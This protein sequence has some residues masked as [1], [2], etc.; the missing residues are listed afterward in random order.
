MCSQTSTAVD[1][2]LFPNSYI[3]V[4]TLAPLSTLTGGSVIRY[5]YFR[6]STLGEKVDSQLN[7][8]FFVFHV[9]LYRIWVWGVKKACSFHSIS[10]IEAACSLISRVLGG[11]NSVL[12][13]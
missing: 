1:L 13:A 6:S 3:D 10:S 11:L 4:A 5:Q 7:I 9:T 12:Q 8:I 2:L